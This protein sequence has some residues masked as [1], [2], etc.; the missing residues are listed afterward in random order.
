MTQTAYALGAALERRIRDR[1]IEDG[2]FVIRSAGSKKVVD[3]AAFKPGQTLFIQCKRSGALPPAS[4]NALY[5]LALSVGAVP[6]MVEN[7]KPR[8]VRWWRLTGRKDGRG[9]RQPMVP[10][11]VDEVAA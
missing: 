8:C 11:E 2:Y 1:L 3:L 4:W 10:F 9:G 7:P 5:D 6:V